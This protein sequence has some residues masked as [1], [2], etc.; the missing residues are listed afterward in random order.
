MIGL[1]IPS[2]YG[3]IS[4]SFWHACEGNSIVKKIPDITDEELKQ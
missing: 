4:E 1:N 2:V 3:G